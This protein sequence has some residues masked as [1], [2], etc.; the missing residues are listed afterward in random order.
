MREGRDKQKHPVT[1]VGFDLDCFKTYITDSRVLN[2][3][4]IWVER[5]RGVPKL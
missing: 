3:D 1:L 5:I 2:R 4:V